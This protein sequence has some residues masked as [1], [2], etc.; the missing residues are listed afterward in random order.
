MY[1]LAVSS[2]VRVHGNLAK[3]SGPGMIR[4]YGFTIEEGLME[5][6]PT[7]ALSPAPHLNPQ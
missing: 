2:Q 5:I 3:A 6:S 7:P 4:L 1:A